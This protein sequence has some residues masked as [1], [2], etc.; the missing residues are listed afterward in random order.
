MEFEKLFSPIRVG[1]LVLRNR[2]IFVPVS[3]NLASVTGEVTDDFI[4]HYAMR[5]KGGS[6]IVTVEN[7]CIDYPTTMEGATQPRLDK[8]EY[9]QV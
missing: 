6:A 3:T 7:A 5:A 4:Y 2:I 9:I 8:D 1:N